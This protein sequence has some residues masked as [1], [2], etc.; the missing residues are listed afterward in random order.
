MPISQK[1]FPVRFTCRGLVDALDATDKFPGASIQLAN[2]LFDQSNPEIMV[3][4][5]GVGSGVTAFAGFLNPGVVSVQVTIGDVTYGLISTSLNA[6]KDEPFAYDN[7][8][9]AFIA[10]SG[11]TNPNTPVSPAMS[12]PWTPPTMAMVGVYLIVTHPGFPGGAT[13]FGWFDLT[14]PAA[15]TW[16][17]GD[18]TSNGLTAVPV[19]V[20][21]FNN[22]AYFAVGNTTQYTDVLTL[23]RTASSQTL[24]LGDAAALTALCGLPIQTTS[25]GVTQALLAF[26][27][28]QVWQITGDPATT[29]SSL[30]ENFISLTTGTQSPRSIAQSPLGVY[31][32]SFSGPRVIDQFG[33]LRDLTHGGLQDQEADIQ[34]PF[35]N[36]LVPSRI[37]GGYTGSIYRVCMQTVI[38]GTT[39]TGDYWFDEHRRRW[40]GPHTFPYDCASQ[41]GSYFLIC[42]NANPGVLFKSEISPSAN[43]V[44]TDAGAAVMITEQSSTFPKTEDMEMNQVVESTIELA[45]NASPASYSI[46]ALDDLGNT[47]NNCTVN[48][49]PAGTLWGVGVWGGFSWASGVNIPT[50]YSV[51]WTAPLVFK[52]MAL[53]I[54]AIASA[55]LAI[56]T[57]FARYKKA[58]YTNV[59]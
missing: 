27:S 45:S 10:L 49:L 23:T 59:R 34:A 26:K 31:F 11:V 36:A 28:F 55:S 53:Y 40:N 16:N 9:A 43:S 19:A 41:Y 5:P 46:T 7:A 25:S 21:N 8:A 12:G 18:C 30:S 24:T 15:P 17:A 33:I 57:F 32:A 48:V 54:T 22:R 58:G 52:K 6:G 2:L 29:P 13:K 14:N 3:S 35:Q 44:Y 47:L 37:A 42:S 1:Q 20:T 39:F 38:R 56:G 51:P 50:T 4:R